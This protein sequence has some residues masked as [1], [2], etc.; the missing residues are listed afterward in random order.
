LGII[1]KR[2]HGLLSTAGHNLGLL[3]R[4]AIAFIAICFFWRVWLF[5]LPELTRIIWLIARHI[6]PTGLA[7]IQIGMVV[8]ASALALLLALA[9]ITTTDVRFVQVMAI[10]GLALDAAG[11]ILFGVASRVIWVGLTIHLMVLAATVWLTSTRRWRFVGVIGMLLLAYAWLGT[12]PSLTKFPGPVLSI[13]YDPNRLAF[14]AVVQD[15]DGSEKYFAVPEQFY[16][17]SIGTLM[18][19]LVEEGYQGYNIIYFKNHYYAIRQGDGPFKLDRF[20]AAGYA[21][22]VEGNSVE[23]VREKIDAIETAPAAPPALALVEEGYQ[24]YNIIRAGDRFC[25]VLQADGAFSLEKFRAGGYTNAVEGNSLEELKRRIDAVETAP[26]TPPVTPPATP[27][28]TPPAPVLVE[29]GYQGYNIIRAGDE[30]C[31]ILQADGAF[32][33]E[34]F[35]AGGYTNAVEGNSLEEVEGKIDAIV[36]NP[37]PAVQP[38]EQTYHGFRIEPWAGKYYAIPQAEGEFD[39]QRIENNDYSQYFSAN[40]TDQIEELI[41]VSILEGTRPIEVYDDYET[42][43]RSEPGITRSEETTVVKEGTSSLK[44]VWENSRGGVYY[45]FP[46]SQTWYHSKYVSFYVYGANSGTTMALQIRF[47]RVSGN[48]WVDFRWTDD[49]SGWK[50]LVFDI[51]NPANASGQAF[52]TD[53]RQVVFRSVSPHSA[54]LYFDRLVWHK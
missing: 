35:R 16:K 22:A 9:A 2:Q 52:W 42:L 25:A 44:V 20:E 27:P 1:I 48:D 33:L 10:L 49:F 17:E 19:G 14:M 39:I 23:E 34:K 31:A 50:R 7:L 41:N 29:E 11:V 15:V 45:N 5:E 37:Q 24:G 3:S 47:K 26:A 13:E 43:W 6:D 40:S 30:F 8:L 4:T 28:V 38:D 36:A 21:Q 54:T 32:S 51:D 18:P 46:T 12:V 53:V